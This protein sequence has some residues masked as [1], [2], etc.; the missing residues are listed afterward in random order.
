MDVLAVCMGGDEKGVLALCPAHGRF[1]AYPVRLLG[2]NLPR[3]KGLADLIAEHIRVPF[4]L[5]AR[6][7]LVLGLRQQELGVAG[8]WV[9]LLNG[10]QFTALGLVGIFPVVKAVFEGVGDG[11]PLADVVDNQARGGRGST[12]FLYNK[13]RLVSAAVWILR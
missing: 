2:G 11:F 6:D 1:I 8:L 7:S 3:G 10:N 13:R 5:P 4:L 9:A 12:S